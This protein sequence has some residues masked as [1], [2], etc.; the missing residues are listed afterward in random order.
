V[1]VVLVV[2]VLVVVVFE[3]WRNSRVPGR[4]K[5][6]DGGLYRGQ[7]QPP[8]PVQSSWVSCHVLGEATHR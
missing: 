3:H 7:A 4:Q 1:V 8:V 6:S 2:L 5:E